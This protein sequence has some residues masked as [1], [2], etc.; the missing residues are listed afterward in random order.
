[1]LATEKY[2]D[3][4]YIYGVDAEK[5]FKEVRDLDMA[6]HQWYSWLESKFET[7]RQKGLTPYETPTKSGGGK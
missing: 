1:M 7:L 5:M 2:D 3:T 6:F 4:E